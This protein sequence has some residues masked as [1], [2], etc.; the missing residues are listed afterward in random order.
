MKIGFIGLGNVGG[1]LAATLL[2]NGYPL[3]VRDL[4]ERLVQSFVQRGAASAASAREMAEW[5]DLII[6][7][8]PSPAASAEVHPSGRSAFERR[9]NTAP[10]PAS[11]PAP[12][13]LAAYSS[14][15]LQLPFCSTRTCRSP[16]SPAPSTG[17]FAGMG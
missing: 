2:R 12:L 11:Q 16:S 1:K 5:V 6:T 8:L 13:R 10:D 7:C 17:A 3:M 14:Y 4:S 15:S 9:S